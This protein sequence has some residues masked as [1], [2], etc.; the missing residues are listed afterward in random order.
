M[1]TKL[2]RAKIASARKRIESQDVSARGLRNALSDVLDAL[3]SILSDVERQE[4]W[5]EAAEHMTE[6]GD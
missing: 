2:V 1:D 6:N 4:Y 3:E 5:D